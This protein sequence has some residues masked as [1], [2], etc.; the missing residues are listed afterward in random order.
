MRIGIGYDSHRFQ[1]GRKLILA[2]VPVD[3]PA[4]L[5]GHSDA[6]APL[7]AVIDAI[8]GAAGL[9]DIGELFPDTDPAWAGA[10][11]ADL[12]AETVRRAARA[13]WTCRNCD[14][15]ILAEAP[16]L[17]DY[18]PAM[19]KRLAA[20]LGLAPEAVSVKAK[21]NEAM[22]FIGRGEGIA[23]IAAVLLGP[24]DDA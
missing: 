19:R 15:T 7:H 13:G 22:G 12:L 20:L 4:G 21:T 10:D 6:D 11:S 16:R 14:L 9:G 5:A 23:A 2:G 3:H 24:A 17:A 8:C 1:P 18:K